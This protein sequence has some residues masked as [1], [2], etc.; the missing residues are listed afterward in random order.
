MFRRI[1][2]NILVG[3]LLLTPIVVT[4]FVVNWLFTFTTNRVLVFLPKHLREGDQEILWRMASLLLVLV[5]MF[6]IGLLVRNILGKRLFQLGD[7]LLGRIPI[8]NSL[9]VGTR[10]VIEALVQQRQTLF[11][12]VV[13]VQYPRPG[14]YAVGFVTAVV[15][16]DFKS[17]LPASQQNEEFISVFIPTT[18]N[19]TSGWFCLVPRSEATVLK[20]TSGEAMKLIMSGGAVFPGDTTSAQTAPKSLLDL[21]HDWTAER[22]NGKDT[23]KPGP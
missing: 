22:E 1:R 11:Q 23:A 13:L 6:A 8:V 10:Q 4:I 3:L 18:P 20:M 17:Y 9:Y 19:P 15:P 5:V 2:N 21:L 7:R 14:V 12:E 16:A